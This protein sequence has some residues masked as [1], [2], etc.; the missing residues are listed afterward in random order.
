MRSVTF[1]FR[2]DVSEDERQETLE[3]ISS[4]SDV[5]KA[6]PLK[7]EAKNPLLLRMAYAYL[8]DDA[9]LDGVVERISNLPEIESA[10]APPRRRLIKTTEEKS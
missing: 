6:S 1:N 9:D 7:P 10:S 5:E 3:R 8:K 2:T 4:W